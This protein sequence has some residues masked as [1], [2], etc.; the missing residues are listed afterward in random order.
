MNISEA[1]KIVGISSYTLRYYEKIGLIK[2][3]VRDKCGNRQYEKNDIEWIRFLMKLK[4]IRMPITQMKLYAELRY[5]GNETIGQRSEML[6]VQKEQLLKRI[7]ELT[8]GVELLDRKL[9]IYKKIGGN[10]NE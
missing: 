1:S 5:K 8:E 9:E 6:K 2:N 4:D 3:I 10:K 7:K